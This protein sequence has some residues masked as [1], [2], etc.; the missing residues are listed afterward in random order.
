[1]CIRDRFKVGHWE[2]TKNLKLKPQQELDDDLFDQL[3]EF[4]HNYHSKKM[5][6]FINETSLQNSSDWENSISKRFLME[7]INDFR[8]KN[9]EWLVQTVINEEA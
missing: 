9:K 1:M 3:V 4:R 8:I 7:G 5:I 2:Y 6:L